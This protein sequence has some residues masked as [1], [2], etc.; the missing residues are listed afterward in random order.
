MLFHLHSQR[1]SHKTFADM[2]EGVSC[3]TRLFEFYSRNPSHVGRNVPP[4]YRGRRSATFN[5]RV[6]YARPKVL[7]AYQHPVL[8]INGTFV[9]IVKLGEVRPRE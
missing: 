6:E 4:A 7:N 3:L 8:T 2:P 1:P 5:D 9:G